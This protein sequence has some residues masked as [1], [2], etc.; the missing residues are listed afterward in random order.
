[1]ATLKKWAVRSAVIL[2]V[3][4][5]GLFGLFVLALSN[6]PDDMCATSVFDHSISPK[7]NAKAVLFEIDCGATTGS[8]RQ[9]SIVPSNTDLA[10]KNP[11]LPK[12]FFGASGAPQVKMNWLTSDRLEIHYPEDATIFR[13]KNVSSGV[14]IEYKQSP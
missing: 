12:S 7:G 9:I 3:L 2:V 10:G 5:G 1:M 13:M 14:I 4:A 8:N 6:M 11:K